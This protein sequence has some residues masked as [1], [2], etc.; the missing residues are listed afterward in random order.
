MQADK[1][2]LL[3]ALQKVCPDGSHT[4]VW[5]AV[6]VREAP[7]IASFL[8]QVRGGAVDTFKARLV[9]RRPCLQAHACACTRWG[10][11]C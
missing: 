8:T 1:E 10:W 6:E 11:A 9:L 2:A 4:E 7:M 5:L 3:S